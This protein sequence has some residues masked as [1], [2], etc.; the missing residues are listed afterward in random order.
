MTII[1][2]LGNNNQMIQI[3]D[4]RLSS[5]GKL[6]DDESNKAGVLFCDNARMTFGY[7]GL[8]N[9]SGFST[10]KWLLK[11]LSESAAPDYTIGEILERLKTNATKTFAEHRALK[12]TSPGLKKLAVMFSGYL[13]L[14]GEV[15]LGSATLSNYHNFQTDNFFPVHPIKL[16]RTF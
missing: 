9:F 4:R 7:T 15:R 3:S 12:T 6:V 11:A 10:M 8:A 13:I 14:D 16:P 1:I 5:K 2:A